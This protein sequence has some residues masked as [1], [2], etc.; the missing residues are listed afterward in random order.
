VPSGAWRAD[1]SLYYQNTPREY[2]E[3]LRD[4]NATDHW[5]ETLYG[6][7]EETGRGA[8][9]AMARAS[10]ELPEPSCTEVASTAQTR[11]TTQKRRDEPGRDRLATRG[12]A[13][14]PAP[15]A[16]DPAAQDLVVTIDDGAGRLWRGALPAGSLLP[17]KSGRSWSYERAPGGAGEIER[18]TL[19][20][21]RDGRSLA[22]SV[23]ATGD[24]RALAAGAGSIELRLGE[25]CL[26]DPADTCSTGKRRAS[27]R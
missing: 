27:C 1:V 22:Y 19:K 23:R 7:W 10:V 24:Q 18:V 17:A 5:G 11:R 20:R 3:H 9:I 14:L 15:D 25:V 6:L 13:S 2:V 16:V 4:A 21:S 8:P 12:G 26:V